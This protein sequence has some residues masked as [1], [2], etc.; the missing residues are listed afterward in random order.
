MRH[1]QKMDGTLSFVCSF[2]CWVI[3]VAD[4]LH[5]QTERFWSLDGSTPVRGQLLKEHTDAGAAEGWCAAL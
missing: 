4:G 5:I 1:F 2:F 3:V